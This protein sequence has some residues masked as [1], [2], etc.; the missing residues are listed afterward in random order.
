MF[1]ESIS[2]DEIN[3][4]VDDLT[5][6]ET[7]TQFRPSNIQHAVAETEERSQV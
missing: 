1:N 6:S 7:V 4:V 5:V 2:S 3:F